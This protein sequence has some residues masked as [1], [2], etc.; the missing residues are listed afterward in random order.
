MF[1]PLA[2]LIFFGARWWWWTNLENNQLHREKIL[3]FLSSTVTG[4]WKE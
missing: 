2:E 4:G 1:R 3:Y